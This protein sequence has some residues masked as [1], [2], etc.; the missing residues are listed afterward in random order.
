MLHNPGDHENL[1]LHLG[2]KLYPQRTL[3]ASSS[4]S[5]FRA[6]EPDFVQGKVGTVKIF[7]D[8]CRAVNYIHGKGYLH[9]NLK[10]N[11]VVLK[12]KKEGFIL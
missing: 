3:L 6:G 2:I 4:V 9:N 12:R 1:P 8:I 11:N 10:S 5:W 7:V